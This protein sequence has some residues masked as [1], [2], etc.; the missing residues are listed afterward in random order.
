VNRYHFSLGDS[1]NGSVGFCASILANTKEEAL[2]IL[3]EDLPIEYELDSARFGQKVDYIAVY[4]NP[5]EIT[6]EDIDDWE[7]DPS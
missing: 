3:Q 1:S 5:D 2:K 6:I 7:E 4:F